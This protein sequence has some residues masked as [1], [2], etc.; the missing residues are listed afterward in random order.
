MANI[1]CSDQLQLG[2]M[3]SR[4][5]KVSEA[6]KDE[7]VPLSLLLT[8]DKFLKVKIVKLTAMG[9]VIEN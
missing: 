4:I 7:Q 5:S 9:I 2:W 1:V 6:G 3:S 8:V